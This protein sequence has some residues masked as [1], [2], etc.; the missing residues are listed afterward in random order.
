VIKEI[1][2]IDLGI[3]VPWDPKEPTLEDVLEKLCVTVVEPSPK[4][5]VVQNALQIVL[6][7]ED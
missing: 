5:D 4:Q 1:I 6:L 3:I 2:L 7:N